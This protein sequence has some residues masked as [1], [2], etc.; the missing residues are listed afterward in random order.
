MDAAPRTATYF[1]GISAGKKTVTFEATRALG[2]LAISSLQGDVIALWQFENIRL[3]KDSGSADH[4]VLSRYVDGAEERLVLDDPNDLELLQR[5]APNLMKTDVRAGT[6]SKIAKWGVCAVAALGL[7]IFVIIPAM[8]NTL[9]TL[10]PPE[11]EAAVGRS[12]LGQIEWALNEGGS[13]DWACSNPDGQ[14]ALDKMM[15]TLMGERYTPYDLNVRVVSHPMVNAFAVPGG[16][17]VFMYGLIEQAETPEE[18]AAVF[19]HELGHVVARDPMRGALRAAG[20]AG[21][22]SLALGDATGGT[23]IAVA[24]DQALS[25]SFT[26][27]AEANADSFAY[28][29]LIE[30]NVPPSALSLMFKRLKD[31]HGD[32][33]GIAEHFSS[34]PALGDRIQAAVDATPDGFQGQPILSESEWAALRQICD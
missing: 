6:Y 3:A 13:D 28:D 19:A 5:L 7:M 8:A 24:A 32:V 17:M 25:S 10:I 33:E 12:V 22:L 9:A 20:S 27:E 15:A 16:H 11:R 2:H 14:A 21:L 29:M 34:H 26:R 23:I 1:D 18:V 4:P 30:A 31:E